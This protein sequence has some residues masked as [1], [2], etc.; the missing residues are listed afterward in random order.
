[1]ASAGFLKQLRSLLPESDWQPVLS[2]L[3]QDRLVWAALQDDTLCSHALE[4]CGKVASAWN[5]ARLG[6]LSLGYSFIET[7]LQERPASQIEPDLSTRLLSLSTDPQDANEDL[8]S[9]MLAALL[10]RESHHQ[11]NQ[12]QRALADLFDKYA[13][14][15]PTVLAC[16]LPIAPDPA[17]LLYS[18]LAGNMFPEPVERRRI[19]THAIFANPLDTHE[20]VNLI[21]QIL[22]ALP[23]AEQLEYLNWL[24]QNNLAKL[25]SAVAGELLGGKKPSTRRVKPETVE[26]EEDHFDMDTVYTQAMLQKLNG[27]E[28]ESKQTLASALDQ[29]KS[30]QEQ[31]LDAL[32]EIN[33]PATDSNGTARPEASG[34]ANEGA[35]AQPAEL[36]KS[37]SEQI[38]GGDLENA[39][40][41][42]H[43]AQSLFPDNSEFARLQAEIARH[44]GH[45]NDTIDALQTAVMLKPEDLSLRKSLASA[46]EEQENWKDALDERRSILKF[47]PEPPEQE[48]LALATTA[49]R[50]S[51][52]QV[53]E[54]ACQT[55][56]E[57]QPE[58]GQA[59]AIFGELLH[60]RG[61]DE[62]ALLHLTRATTMAPDLPAP[63]L[64]ISRIYRDQGNETF[65]NDTL[66]AASQVL[67]DSP[68]IQYALGE[69]CLA[70]SSPSEAL[71]Y[72]R[73]A[74]K[75]DPSSPVIRLRL[76]ENLAALGLYDE[77]DRILTAAR[78][79][80]AADP[81]LAM[82]H[83]RV[84]LGLGNLDAALDTVTLALEA[85]PDRVTTFSL[86][87]EILEAAIDEKNNLSSLLSAHPNL[88]RLTGSLQDMLEG[89]LASRPESLDLQM[90]AAD[91]L[92]ETGDREKALD[93]YRSLLQKLPY[94]HP[95]SWR[96]QFGL[97][98]IALQLGQL[99]A[100]LVSLKEAAHLMPE[101][102]DILKS[103]AETYRLANLTR[104]ALETAQAVTDLQPGDAGN[105]LWQADVC[106]KLNEPA[107]AASAIEKALALEPDRPDLVLMHARALLAAGDAAP[108][109]ARLDALTAS[110]ELDSAIYK[111]AADLYTEMALPARTNACLKKAVE[112]ST[113]PDI[114]LLTDLAKAY[115]SQGDPTEAL[116]TIDQ[117]LAVDEENEELVLQRCSLLDQLGQPGEARE[118]LVSLLNSSRIEGWSNVSLSQLHSR[119]AELLRESGDTAGALSSI[120]QAQALAPD[121]QSIQHLVLQIQ[122]GCLL[123]GSEMLRARIQK[124]LTEPTQDQ[125]YP[126]SLVEAALDCGL[127]DEA[128][129]AS[130]LFSDS[131]DPVR[132]AAVQARLD[133][134][135]DEQQDAFEHFEAAQAD[136]DQDAIFKDQLTRLNSLAGAALAMQQWLKAYEFSQAALALAPYEPLAA[137]NAFKAL[138]YQHEEIELCDYLKIQAHRPASF[139]LPAGALDTLL[140][141]LPPAEEYAH[142]PYWLARGAALTG[143]I[144][145]KKDL[146]NSPALHPNEYAGSIFLLLAAGQVREV[147]RMLETWPEN[148]PLRLYRAA[149][150]LEREASTAAN[151]AE[152]LLLNDPADPL[153][154]ALKAYALPSDAFKACESIEK[155]LAVWNDEPVWHAYAAQLSHELG[156]AQA[157]I[158][159]ADELIKLL[160]DNCENQI[161]AGSAYLDAGQTESAIHCLRRAVLLE[162]HQKSAWMLLGQACYQSGNRND[163]QDALERAIA[164]DPDDAEPLLLS[165]RIALSAEAYDLAAAR[166]RQ[167][168]ELN[169]EE[170]GGLLLLTGTLSKQGRHEEALITLE[171][172][173]LALRKSLPVQVEQLMLTQAIKGPKAILTQLE[174]L[175]ARNREDPRVLKAL[176]ECYSALGQDS[177]AE[178]T[179]MEALKLAGDDA[180]LH[181]L[182]GKIQRAGGQL[183][184]AIDHLS[185]VIRL[186]S[187][188]VEAYLELAQAYTDRRQYEQAVRVYQQATIVCPEDHRPYLQAGMLLKDGADF[189]AAEVMLRKA[190]SLNPMDLNIHSQLGALMALNFVHHTQDALTRS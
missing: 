165:G 8:P 24:K 70:N 151:D 102:T 9:A 5:P 66:K 53:A 134:L 127:T 34:I 51:Q 61:D 68:E 149:A 50:A 117:A 63:W 115:A 107:E 83:A 64:V 147:D 20:R 85:R 31:L 44:T 177:E 10:A 135:A 47:F 113:T 158:K 142:L 118:Y 161:S 86:L 126:L 60:A 144:V 3:R 27:Q 114:N 105:L 45:S 65:S 33:D 125:D 41:G 136:Q 90:L 155:A 140:A 146:A 121:D 56:L 159:H 16:L 11:T 174:S 76:A 26:I 183:D 108:A 71:V 49:I 13:A 150:L 173:S 167:V 57:M 145:E 172:A 122:R 25:S 87:A 89:A 152:L 81:E 179:A 48:L 58:N 29:I 98:R 128:L 176:A 32:D 54:T 62:K 78:Q 154:L 109:Q 19:L 100:A 148:R 23:D 175:G 129:R 120:S 143:A 1:M 36:I 156:N 133:A 162:P 131:A 84:L 137:L 4:I 163:A 95:A 187:T 73:K 138:I 116:Q 110:P 184:Q 42:L 38:H 96:A 52:L 123:V 103:L 141:K 14:L 164:I 181:Y 168:L 189:A 101:R 170:P 40:T 186:E 124:A 72:L 139:D 74:Y 77:A 88:K 106:L 119:L 99:D 37:I 169:P 69:N 35:G 28:A 79:V 18:F 59:N 43:E 22:S 82:L 153:S 91:L 15:A 46:Y 132:L 104:E 17:I 6:L 80:N 166:A 92:A 39:A 30:R 21:V 7:D 190:A 2:A 130:E 55:V 93:R 94:K 178:Q 182:A 75:Y 188:H 171:S 185:E 67:P 12:W 157:R 180:N 160:P 112:V 111:S 97:G